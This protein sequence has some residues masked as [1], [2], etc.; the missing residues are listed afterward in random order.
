[1]H[2]SGHLF[3]FAFGNWNDLRDSFREDTVVA[4]G[5][6]ISTLRYTFC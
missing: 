4:T 5:M 3:C 2:A 1:M 6:P